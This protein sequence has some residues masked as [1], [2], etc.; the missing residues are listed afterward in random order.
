MHFNKYR[1]A[2]LICILAIFIC[3]LI[4]YLP[5]LKMALTKDE[6]TIYYDD[7]MVRLQLP[8]GNDITTTNIDGTEYAFIPTFSKASKYR[9]IT[10]Q[11]VCL[12]QKSS[13]SEYSGSENSPEIHYDTEQLLT[14]K[15]DENTLFEGKIIFCHSQN[16]YTTFINLNN[17]NVSEMDKY[18]IGA[19]FQIWTPEGSNEYQDN[20][21]QIRCRGNSTFGKPK[22]AYTVKFNKAASVGN[23]SPSKKFLLL[24][25]AF[26]G[27]RIINKLVFDMLDQ[28]GMEYATD[29]V[30]TD[31][32]INGE[33]RGNY[34]LC[35]SIDI[36]RNKINTADLED[37]NSQLATVTE[38][39]HY[40]TGNEKGYLYSGKIQDITG[41]Y[42]VEKDFDEYYYESPC[43]FANDSGALFTIKYPNNASKEEVEY[44]HSVFQN[45]E[46]LIASDDSSILNYIDT[47]SFV[48][49]YL[50]EE[51]VLNS[52]AGIAS[53]YFYKKADD[54]LLYAG[55][56]WDYDGAFGEMTEGTRD[57][58]ASILD[59]DKIRGISTL[60]WDKYLAGNEAYRQK[61]EE[62]YMELRPMLI[63]SYES[64]IDMYADTVKESVVM[65]MIR[66]PD[67][68]DETLYKDYG[69]TIRYLKYFFYHRLLYMDRM[70]GVDSSDIAIPENSD[71]M[72]TVTFCDNDTVFEMHVRDGECIGS[73]MIP[74]ISND[75]GKKWIYANKNEELSA[76]APIYEDVIV[77][78]DYLNQE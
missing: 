36:S 12:L 5:S 74:E 54:P 11:Q 73:D 21:I 16:I 65:D 2:F 49:R 18:Y 42:I 45:V 1:V 15:D 63:N 78:L 62:T 37:Y 70:F 69:N 9:A 52:D 3:G 35:E 28:S 77:N 32:Y 64:Q 4:P 14:I 51:L 61:L 25:N 39:D 7:G 29:A 55:P 60:Q 48:K 43:G 59:L 19:D 41:G 53:Y 75:P 27:S 47:D 56:G 67:L 30:W 38:D 50:I 33:Y 71:V 58:N 72:H 76:Y 26:D 20:K 13:D 6:V 34:L 66:W 44:I 8:S 24:A 31:L 57:Y 46:D 23:M 68:L 10:G 22:K 40:E 17:F